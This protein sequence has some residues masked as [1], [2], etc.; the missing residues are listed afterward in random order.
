M[1]NGFSGNSLTL[2]GDGRVLA[3]GGYGYPQPTTWEVFDPQSEQWIAGGIMSA[4]RAWH[5]ATLLPNGKVLVAGGA[6]NVSGPIA[7]AELYDPIADTWGPASPML[8]TR[9]RHTA[10][11]LPNGK[12]L[13]AGGFRNSS[14]IP[15]YQP[16]DPTTELYDPATDTWA[17][18]A[19]MSMPHAYHAAT[20]LG[21]G[22]VLVTGGNSRL[23]T[24]Y[25]Y[26]II[27]PEIYADYDNDFLSD[28]YEA[29]HD[30]LVP[31]TADSSADPDSDGLNSLTE[32]II[33]TDPCLNDT[34]TDNCPDGIEVA[35]QGVKEPDDPL[36][37][38]DFPDFDADGRVDFD[39]FEYFASVWTTT[40]SVADLDS[41]GRVDFDDFESFAAAWTR[42]CV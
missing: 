18:G 1:V 29:A 16:P 32:S 14:F 10:T 17:P 40:N 12:V 11:L 2:L 7:T 15:G 23:G 20:L 25:S 21:D 27:W 5:T 13:V 38:G 30:C 34:D 39:D 35:N 3:A 41:D 8:R 28:G 24:G 9:Y 22:A 4:P 42:R 6:D 19:P 37:K 31:N 33:V 36:D 26:G